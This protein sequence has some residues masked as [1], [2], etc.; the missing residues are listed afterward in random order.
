MGRGRLSTARG[1]LKGPQQAECKDRPFRQGAKCCRRASGLAAGVRP[2]GRPVRASG[3]TS[4]L[5]WAVLGPVGWTGAACGLVGT[6]LGCPVPQGSPPARRVGC[7][8]KRGHLGRPVAA[9]RGLRGPRGFPKSHSEGGQE[10]R[11][12]GPLPRTARLG[13]VPAALRSGAQR[14]D[15]P[16][17]H[18]WPRGWAHGL[19]GTAGAAAPRPEQPPEAAGRAL[20]PL[21]RQLP[22]NHGHGGLVRR[23]EVTKSPT[24]RL[25]E[26]AQKWTGRERLLGVGTGGGGL[27]GAAEHLL[28]A[29]APGSPALGPQAPHPDYGYLAERLGPE[30]CRG[31]RSCM[32]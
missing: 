29:P 12:N 23:R 28:G 32:R 30:T 21:R 1:P 20:G 22:G 2:V 13:P 9:A 15:A 17:G 18:G 26:A 27:R 8:V 10:P 11:D 19:A 5:R 7:G 24:D 4:R 25:P 3:P 16:P 31:Q 14:G 6:P